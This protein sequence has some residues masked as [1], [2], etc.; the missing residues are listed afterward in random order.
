MLPLSVSLTKFPFRLYETKHKQSTLSSLYQRSVHYEALNAN[1][2]SLHTSLSRYFYSRVRGSVQYR[3]E[4]ETFVIGLCIIDQRYI[5]TKC[6][7]HRQHQITVFS[8]LFFIVYF[9]LRSFENLTT[10]MYTTDKDGHCSAV[11][12]TQTKTVLIRLRGDKRGETAA[13]TT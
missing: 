1:V 8:H 11:S 4:I 12:F 3:S 5:I 10:H 13:D 7:S 2:Q 9:M 6:L